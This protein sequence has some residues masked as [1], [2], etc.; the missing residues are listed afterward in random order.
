M[1]YTHPLFCLLI[2]ALM[3][4]VQSAFAQDVRIHEEILS[5]PTYGFSKPNPVP[6]LAENPKIFPYY[7]FEA[8]EHEATN[9]NWTVVTLENEYIKV[10]VLPEIGGKVWGAIEKST[11]EEFLYKNEVIKFRNIAMRGPWTS[12][13]IEFNFGIIGHHPSTA[14]PVDYLTRTNSDG[15]VSCVVG[16]TDLPSN[17]RWTVEIRLEKDKAYFETNASWYNASH[18]PESYYN[19]MTAAAAATYDFEFFIPGD[20]Y[21]EHNGDAHPWPIDEEGRNLAMYKNNTFGPSKSY[22]V[23]GEYNDF[24]GGYYHDKQFG[25]GTWAP[26][27]EM[28][29]QKLWLW[30][31]SRAGGIWEDLLTDTDGQYIEF[32]AGRMFDQYFPGAINP[33]SQVGFDPYMMDSW[34]EIWFPYKDIGGMEDASSHG[35]LNVEF[36]NGLAT[37]GLNALQQ[38]HQ[39][40]EVNINGELAFSEKM[41][42]KPMTIFL[43][44]LPAEP[45]DK[46][47]VKLVGTD[48]SYTN[49]P[50]DKLI[51]RPFYPDANLIVSETEQLFQDGLEAVEFREYALA[52]STLS[53]LIELDPSHRAG[54]V[55]LAELE[56]RKTNYERALELSNTVLKMDTYNAGANYI[57]GITY[58]AMGDYLNALESLGWSARDIKYRSISFALMSEIYLKQEIFDKAQQY[59]KKSLIFNSNNVNAREI[60]LVISR[61]NNDKEAFASY[62]N[63]LLKIDPLNHFVST[64]K[65]IFND[66]ETESNSIHIQ[67]IQNEFEKET[68]LTLALRYYELGLDSDALTILESNDK[69]VKNSLWTAYL[70]KETKQTESDRLLREAIAGSPNLIFPYRRQTIPILEWAVSQNDS[71]KLKYY[72][73]QNYLAVGLD[74]KGKSILNELRD[75]PDSDIFYRF[76]GALLKESSFEDRAADYSKALELNQT[77]WKVWEE[78]ILFQLKNEKH[79]EAYALSNE[80]V[81]KYS[82]NYNIELAH[83]KALLHTGRFAEVLPIMETIQVLPY[84]H[85]SESRKIYERAHLGVARDLLDKKDYSAAIS[86]LK[87]SKEWPENIGVGK[88]Y[89]PDERMQDYYLA[90]SYEHA[91]NVAKRDELLEQIVDYTDNHMTSSDIDHVFGLLALKK[92]GRQT[93]LTSVISTLINEKPKH[94]MALALFENDMKKASDLKEENNIPEDIWEGLLAALTF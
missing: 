47:E 34:S 67:N 53:E 57:A 1:I 13:G 73:A 3:S 89:G 36:E 30:N 39:E 62:A 90:M 59:A 17:T 86:I 72:L 5:L 8:Y 32:Q 64:E 11:G 42:L 18:L 56:Y 9:K 94:Q 68:I 40:L 77:D 58:R 46:I 66:L 82:G 50:D 20:K 45:G 24:F 65:T 31:L 92:L 71:W 83:A 22:H 55:A 91:G 60:L 15:S 84:E 43:K 79:D 80:A 61:I 75:I 27:E 28:P 87:K 93:Q 7:K 25:F 88:P 26:Y 69:N 63:T 29:G 10:Y 35:V 4:T 12:G 19:W 6:I 48:L 49:D 52:D 81:K 74:E 16:N 21:V 38:L 51:K 76:R 41:D 14:T 78:N 44:E 70:T 85:A 33:I 23:V 37:I 2:I 54:H